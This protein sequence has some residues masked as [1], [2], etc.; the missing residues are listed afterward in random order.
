MRVASASR[1][2]VVYAVGVA[3][4]TPNQMVVTCEHCGARYRLDQGRIP[5]R[6]A[7]ITCPSCSHVFVV[8]REEAAAPSEHADD[9]PSDVHAL[10]FKSVGISTWKVKTGIGLV[11]DFSD[12][13]TLRRYLKEGRVSDTDSL[14]HDGVDW[15][16]ISEI[17]DLEV[18]FIDTYVAARDAAAPAPESASPPVEPE[19]EPEA[20]PLVDAEPEADGDE[21]AMDADAIAADLLGKIGIED[22][23]DA[24]PVAPSSADDIAD[25]LLAAVEAAAT[26]SDGEIELDMDSLLEEASQAVSGNRAPAAAR[27]GSEQTAVQSIAKTGSEDTNPHQFVDPFEALKQSR[28]AKATGRKRRKNKQRAAEV[29]IA[30]EKRTRYVILGGLLVCAGAAYFGISQPAG[31]AVDSTAMAA[32]QEKEAEAAK[33]AAIEQHAADARTRMQEELSAALKDVKTEEIEAFAVEE[34]QLIAKIPDEFMKGA[35]AKAPFAPPGQAA[36]VAAGT[37]QRTLSAAD[38]IG[39][40][41]M[42]S[43]SAKYEEAASSYKSALQLNP[44]NMSVRAKLGHALYKG[45]NIDAAEVELRAALSG[46]A[47]AAHKYLGHM[48][49][50]QGDISGA[51]THYQSY[52]RSGPPDAR[53]I[54][55]MIQQMTP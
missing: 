20:E 26:E 19:T 21:P 25:E 18:H 53:A 4:R 38:H 46:G 36:P 17:G 29:A 51:N 42:A 9:R 10:D 2:V 22:D 15:T 30:K 6:G 11:Y 13:K 41:D 3:R 45:G 35:K 52:L 1:P 32:R 27:R 28:E 43:R 8:Y 14:S 37:G 31:D 48:A 39:M 47:V 44:A 33:Q 55:I 12:Y 16:V 7:R 5:G 50:D 54:E 23:S 49:R 40:G 34:E 24:S